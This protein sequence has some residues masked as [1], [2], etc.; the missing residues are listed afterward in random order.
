MSVWAEFNP[1]KSCVI[2]TLPDP[3][4]I[5]P[6]TKLQKRYKTYFEEILKRSITELQDLENVLT[7]YGVTIHRSKQTYDMHNGKT[8]NTPP[9][10]VRD[11]Y[12][13]YGDNLFKGNFA[14]DWN[15]EVPH[16]CDHVFE[17]C[18]F[19]SQHNLPSGNK[20]FN[21]E[22]TKFNAD[23]DLARPLYH[24]SLTLK[25]GHDIII[26][27][28][29]GK[30]GN[31]A[32]LKEYKDW[33]STINPDARFHVLDTVSHIDSQIFL[34][35]PGLMLTCLT[36]DKLPDFFKSWE[37]IYVDPVAAQ[38]FHKR[39]KY[40]HKKFHPVI[41]QVFYNF[42]ETCTEETYF[43]LNSLSI[44]ES[45]VLF[46]GTHPTLFKKLEKKGIDCIPISMK[47]TTF[48]DTGV[49]CVTNELEREGE[50]VDYA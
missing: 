29:P 23:K 4:K 45:T 24:P 32:G 49:H 30:E 38:L 13:V 37:K 7:S 3:D 10:A 18:N 50:L 5:I 16:C 39:N 42:L 26:S 44:N 20:F 36:N 2:G 40:R 48:W 11:I 12:T 22:F 33:I 41:A 9:L 6:F 28:D 15:K 14:F 43:N 35:R 19:S 46:T 21:G 34:V 17:K 31:T 25:C 47:A 27:K 8:I 1:L